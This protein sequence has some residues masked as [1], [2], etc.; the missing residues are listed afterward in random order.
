M[1]RDHNPEFSE[2]EVYW[3]YTDYRDMINLTKKLFQP[4]I[5]GKWEEISYIDAM[6]KYA[7]KD[8]AQLKKLSGSAI[9]ELFKRNVR[10]KLVK[11]TIL[12]GHPKS[13][14]PLAKSFDDNPDF[15]ERFQFILDGT[16]IANGFSELNDPIEQRERME[17][18]EKLYRKGDEEVTRLDED[19]L[20]ALEYGMPPAAG[21][22]TSE[23]LFAV[24]MNKPVRETVFFPLMKRPKKK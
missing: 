4:F 10:P 1:D 8:W 18:Q 16:E 6:K 3:A 7:N 11:P 14:S 19:Y 21:F 13:M 20:E 23:R 24:I 17:E 22:G 5:K 15:T 9:D 12:C 2:L